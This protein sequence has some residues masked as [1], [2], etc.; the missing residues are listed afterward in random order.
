MTENSFAVVLLKNKNLHCTGFN[1]TRPFLCVLLVGGL[2]L[3]NPLFVKV[4]R[5]WINIFAA[6][7]AY[8]KVIHS[9]VLCFCS[10]I[11]HYYKNI[12]HFWMFV[13][14]CQ[15]KCIVLTSP[16][17]NMLHVRF[18]SVS[19]LNLRFLLKQLEIFKCKLA[20]IRHKP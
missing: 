16:L 1:L 14:L 9:I 17:F 7:V 19:F 10:L 18:F 6:G 5:W 12:L 11:R 2:I 15:L 13:F 4:D 3:D 20:Q 8:V